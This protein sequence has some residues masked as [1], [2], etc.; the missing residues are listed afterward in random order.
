VNAKRSCEYILLRNKNITC[1]V[2]SVNDDICTATACTTAFYGCLRKKGTLAV[3]VS[4]DL[5]VILF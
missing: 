4:A 5:L 3:Y 1:L 2:L